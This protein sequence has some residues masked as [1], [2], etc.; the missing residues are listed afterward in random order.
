MAVTVVSSGGDADLGRPAA[1]GYRADMSRI[2][3]LL[4]VFLLSFASG[5][6]PTRSRAADAPSVLFLICDDLNCDLACYGHPQVRTPNIDRLAAR[7]RL[8]SNAYCQF[9]LCGPSRASFMT[10]LYP[11]QTLVRRNAVYIRE[12]LPRVKTLSQMFRDHGHFATRIGKIYHYNVPRHIGTSGHDD[13]DSWNY[14]INP[15]GRD[16]DDEDRIFSLRPGSFGGTLSWL[17]ADGTD[18]EQ[19]DGIAATHAVRLL[20]RYAG[21]KRRFFMAVGLFRPHTPYVAPKRYFDLYPR[22]KIV[23]PSVPDGY[24]AT[25]PA[26]ARR[27]IRRKKDQIDLADDLARRAIQAYHASITFADAQVGRILDAL[28]ESGLSKSTVVLFTS[29]HGYHMGE[30]G[31]WQKTTLFENAARVPLIIAGP[32]V[33]EPGKPTRAA[34]EMVDFYPTLAELCGWK[35][36]AGLPGVSLVPA[37]RDPAARPRASALTQYAG[38]YSLRTARWRLTAWGEDGEQGTELYDHDSDAAEMVNLA[39]RPEHA[40]RVRTLSLELRKRVAAARRAPEGLRQIEPRTRQR[41]R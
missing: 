10:G 19:T 23:V 6:S 12:R 27:S 38:G 32:G 35:P 31:H 4:L 2:P 26:P 3:P 30:H 41:A 37:L 9:P 18:E 1:I 15:R 28:E 22:D 21:E 25:I 24:L 7:G 36:P 17:A 34:A 5:A 39:G 29:D 13:P 40:E 20:K 11:D 33:R 14:T 8:F 16:V